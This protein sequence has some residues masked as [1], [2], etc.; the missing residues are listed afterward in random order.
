MWG[1]TVEGVL[2]G[3]L[4]QFG[5]DHDQRGGAVGVQHTQLPHPVD[6]HRG[7]GD[8][9]R[10]DVVHDRQDPVDDLVEVDL[11]VDRHGQRI[12]HERDRRHPPNRFDERLSTLRVAGAARLQAQQRGHGLQVVLD[13]VMDLAD[14]RVLGQQRAVAA[15]DLGDVADQHRRAH[16]RAVHHQRQRAQQHRRPTRVD[17]HAHART[18]GQRIADVVGQL[19]GLER[20]G[21]QRSGD[22][23]EVV[24]F[25]LGGQPH[26][27][28]RGDR[29]RAGERHHAGFVES[30]EAV[31]GPRAGP[32][33]RQVAHVGERA[34]RQHVQQVDRTGPVRRLQRAGL[35]RR[36]RGL[37]GQ[38]RHHVAL[39]AYRHRLDP[40]PG[41]AVA[42]LHGGGADG[43][44]VER[45]SDDREVLGLGHC[46]HRVGEQ[47]RRRGVRPHLGHA[48]QHAVVAADPHQI[49]GERQ[50]GQQLPFPD[51][52]VQVIDRVS[53]QHGVLG[54]QVTEGR[55]A[56]LADDR[57]QVA[58]LDH[59]T[60][61]DAD[62]AD[63]AGDLGEHR[64]LHLHRLQQHQGVA[65]TDLIALADHDLEHTGHDLG[66]NILGHLHPTHSLLCLNG[67][68]EPHDR[69]DRA[70]T[71][72]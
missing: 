45:R 22:A 2:D 54:E 65:F 44:R 66:A 38:R 71:G 51:D 15:F 13:P 37:V 30:D 26:A 55:H 60:D 16:P 33:H 5:D 56:G 24:A 36:Q 62:L 68:I 19:L 46:A 59:V 57:D 11:F 18:A 48:D 43:A 14:R 6:P 49:V 41:G 52:G 9:G 3:V 67:S 72:T 17:L 12:V 21:D 39:V 47:H 20:V 40:N 53:G 64:D 70:S 35:T 69:V 34:F 58:G 27:V 63:G 29:V 1:G 28:I 42:A 7:V 23:D 50:V 31:P 10:R 25:Q 61:R 32:R 4:H 8:V